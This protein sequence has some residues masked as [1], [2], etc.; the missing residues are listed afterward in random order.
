MN[1]LERLILDLKTNGITRPQ[2]LEAIKKVPREQFVPPRYIQQAYDNTALPIDCEQTISQ[3]FVVALMTQV[4]LENGA[5][6]KILEI[7]TGSGYQTAILATLFDEIY[8]IERIAPL[9]KHAKMVLDDLG[10][11]NIHYKIADGSK[12][13]SDAAPFDGIIVTAAAEAVPSALA[14]Q[15]NPK[16]SAFVIPVG[17]RF[18]GQRL[19]LYT[20][21]QGI[22]EARHLIDVQF[23]PL[24]E[25]H[26]NP[27]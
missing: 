24:I 22:Q 9:Q 5:K 10:F 15:M 3:P 13:W 8:T 23:V 2:V 27:K 4:L 7:G 20:T 21:H 12:G 14:A 25:N 11:Q 19:M 17:N 16:K 1:Q 6:H 18:T 26:D